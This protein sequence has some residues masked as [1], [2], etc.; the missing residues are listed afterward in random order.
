MVAV[1]VGS[2]ELKTGV[3]HRSGIHRYGGIGHSGLFR[4]RNS[5]QKVFAGILVPLSCKLQTIA[6]QSKINTHIVGLLF[7]P[8]KVIVH[9]SGNGRTGHYVTVEIVSH[10]IA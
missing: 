3:V 2:G 4:N 7:L 8:C 5:I 1:T 10:I 9:E 6:E